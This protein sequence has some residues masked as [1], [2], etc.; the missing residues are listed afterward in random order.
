M[1]SMGQPVT[2]PGGLASATGEPLVQGSS[3]SMMQSAVVG[4]DGTVTTGIAGDPSEDART[5]TSFD[6][7]TN[8]ITTTTV[9]RAT[10]SITTTSTTV[11]FSAAD[12]A[13]GGDRA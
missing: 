13:R 9:D 4:P 11:P 10:G 5:A 7:T 3:T 8:T 1:A 6:P 2:Q 12:Q